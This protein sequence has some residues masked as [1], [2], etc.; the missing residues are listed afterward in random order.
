MNHDGS[1][2]AIVTGKLEV[3][4]AAAKLPGER[5]EEVVEA[6]LSEDKTEL[7]EIG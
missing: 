4:E 3:R 7:E 1:A 5:P 2:G 6:N